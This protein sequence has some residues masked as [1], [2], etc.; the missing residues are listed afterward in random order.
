MKKTPRSPQA[1][2]CIVYWASY[3]CAGFQPYLLAVYLVRVT[4]DENVMPLFYA[5]MYILSPFVMSLARRLAERKSDFLVSR[6]SVLL[7]AVTFIFV[8]LFPGKLLVLISVVFSIA[9]AGYN[10]SFYTLF[11]RLTNDNTSDAL[12]GRAMA[13]ANAIMLILP[14]GASYLFEGFDGLTGYSIA[15]IVSMLL[16][17]LLFALTHGYFLGKPDRTSPAAGRSVSMLRMPEARRMLVMCLLRS[18]RD[19][20]FGFVVNMM[21]LAVV[22]SEVLIGWNS[23]LCG[24][25]ALAS[26]ILYGKIVRAKNRRACIAASVS[27]LVSVAVVVVLSPSVPV[28]L[29]FSFL[30]SLLTNFI[31]IS[32][33]NYELS[34]M[35]ELEEK[36]GVSIA[37]L[38]A[39]RE[40]F[41]S[42]GR[43]AGTL[44]VFAF[45]F[46]IESIG[47][48]VLLILAT[49][50]LL[51]ALLPRAPRERASVQ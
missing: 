26:A 14:I 1:F 11:T 33:M 3:L 44:I 40:Y 35:R 8:I 20:V 17:F 51:L 27:V 38:M 32:P 19:G 50:Y 23:S 6:L 22:K 37:G 45:S 12:M 39:V 47:L 48:V 30:N 21:L 31:T 25:A 46:S 29:I 13:G 34:V 2:F 10:S 41:V 49:Q 18:M 4:G 36:Y 24:F 9:V 7:H 42:F 15:A 28:I 43:V 5:L 16:G